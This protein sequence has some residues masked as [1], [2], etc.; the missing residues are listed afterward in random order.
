MSTGTQ[1]EVVMPQMGVSVAEG[2]VTRWL[3]QP[4]ETIALDEPLLEI[5]TD[6]VDTEVPSPGEGVVAEIRVQEG[7]TVEVGTVLAVIGS[8][9]AE[10]ATD[11]EPAEEVSA[12]A[13]AEPKPE[14]EPAAPADA[15]FADEAPSTPAEP[16]SAPPEQ[17]PVPAP[18]PATAGRGQRQDVHLAGRRADR[19][20]A[21]RR[22][23]RDPRYGPG[24]PRHEEGHPG[25]HRV[26]RKRAGRTCAAHRGSST[27]GDRCRSVRRR[28]RW[29][30]Q[31]RRPLLRLPP[32]RR[33]R[34]L[35]RPS[36]L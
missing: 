12:G 29:R 2:T 19:G 10:P 8:G 16:P 30:P 14:P 4:G 28:P 27:G 7:E 36:R 24:R 21:W 13:A 35:S 32:L 9:V 34:L 33:L 26:R 23:R 18:S 17:A 1:V 5:S 31:L 20:R 3:K 11:G 25:V 15:P 6:K 22:S